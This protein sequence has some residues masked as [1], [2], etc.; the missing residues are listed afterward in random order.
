M[1]EFWSNLFLRKKQSSFLSVFLPLPQF[2]FLIKLLFLLLLSLHRGILLYLSACSHEVSGN[3]ISE[4]F[5]VLCCCSRGRETYT[6]CTNSLCPKL[7]ETVLVNE[8]FNTAE[9]CNLPQLHS[10]LF[11][12]PSGLCS[13]N[14]PV[15]RTR[16][17]SV[18]PKNT[19]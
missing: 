7:M 18:M 11:E 6:V 9:S 8:S 13:F 5:S 15:K 19:K 14:L 4:Y 12:H 10:H 3:F 2:H 16:G 1:Y 17:S